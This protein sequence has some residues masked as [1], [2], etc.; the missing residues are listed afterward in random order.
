MQ[1]I[2]LLLQ[3]Y[4]QLRPRDGVVRDAFNKTFVDVFGEK[5]PIPHITVAGVV[6]RVEVSGALKSEMLLQKEHFQEVFINYLGEKIK[7]D[8]VV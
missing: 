6:V 1:A 2:T 8:R 5:V 7:V 3:K 4:A